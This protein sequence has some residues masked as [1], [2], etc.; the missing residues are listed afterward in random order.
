MPTLLSSGRHKRMNN[1]TYNFTNPLQ[2]TSEYMSPQL[3]TPIH[4]TQVPYYPPPCQ[5]VVYNVQCQNS[6]SC[7]GSIDK[8]SAGFFHDLAS[9]ILQMAESVD[10]RIEDIRK[11]CND[12]QQARGFLFASVDTPN[13]NISIGAEYVIYIQRFGPPQLGK[14]DQDK[15]AEIRAEINAS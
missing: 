15:L 1:H 2:Y 9:K 3:H 12:S 5:P 7:D 11:K 8:S 14:F 4:Y 10:A 13:M 6:N